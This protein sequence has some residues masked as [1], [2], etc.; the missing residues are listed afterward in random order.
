MGVVCTRVVGALGLRED[1]FPIASMFLKD[2]P[3]EIEEV[4]L[5]GEELKNEEAV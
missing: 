5:I 4:L 2:D 1:I 3:A